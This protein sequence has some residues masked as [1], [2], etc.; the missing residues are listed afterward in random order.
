MLGIYLKLGNGSLRNLSD[1]CHMNDSEEAKMAI[2]V[3]TDVKE[4]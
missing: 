1:G 2:A 3:K 4:S